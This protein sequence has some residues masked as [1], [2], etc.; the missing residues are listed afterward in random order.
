M[1]SNGVRG[2][3]HVSQSTADLLILAGKKNWVVAREDVI[4]AKGKGR[5]QTYFVERKAKT[6]SQVSSSL[7]S[8]HSDRTPQGLDRMDSIADHTDRDVDG[9]DSMVEHTDRGLDY[10]DLMFDHTGRDMDQS[11]QIIDRTELISQHSMDEDYE[12]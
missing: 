7:F 2:K 11:D 3:I 12:A 4:E 10:A 6:A 8:S 1:E 5:M 9:M